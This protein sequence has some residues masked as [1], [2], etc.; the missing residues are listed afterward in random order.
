MST[1][2]PGSQNSIFITQRPELVGLWL[3]VCQAIS[4]QLSWAKMLASTQMC[5]HWFYA[6]LSCTRAGLVTVVHC[7][8]W[9][10]LFYTCV[11][12]HQ[13]GNTKCDTNVSIFI[14]FESFQNFQSFSILKQLWKP[15]Q[16]IW[17]NQSFQIFNLNSCVCSDPMTWSHYQLGVT[18]TPYRVWAAANIVN[19]PF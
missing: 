15:Q 14:N 18:T 11:W 19:H 12:T 4:R 2:D 9:T 16:H 7:F 8:R 1:H 6:H 3:E 17:N 5:L 13:M 10:P